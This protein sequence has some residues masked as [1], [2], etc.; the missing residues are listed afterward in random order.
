MF[1]PN[2]LIAGYCEK[3]LELAKKSLLFGLDWAVLPQAAAQVSHKGTR[4]AA[5]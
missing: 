5:E 4:I 3:S 2:G 1:P